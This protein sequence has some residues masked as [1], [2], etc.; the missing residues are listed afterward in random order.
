LKE[1]NIFSKETPNK[2]YYHH[3]LI[4]T[5]NYS[6][7]AQQLLF[8]VGESWVFGGMGWWN[9]MGFE[10]KEINDDYLQLS[11]KLYDLLLQGIIG[12]TNSN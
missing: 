1:L 8:A 12:S 3:D 2:V 4:V 9:D 11:Q 7:A 10:N 6:L 5:K